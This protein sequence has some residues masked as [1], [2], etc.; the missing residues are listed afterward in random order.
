MNSFCRCRNLLHDTLFI[1]D[2]GLEAQH[3]KHHQ[4]GQN[5]SEEVDERD[6]HCIKMTVVID[7]IVA[8][9]GYDSSE[10][11][12]KGEEDLGGRFPPHLRLQ[13]LLQLRDIE[14][15]GDIVEPFVIKNAARKKVSPWE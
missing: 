8:G 13:H 5:G 10:P 9:E 6:E 11:Q 4:R 15:D 12:T 14:R 2:V 3:G 1:H 7:L